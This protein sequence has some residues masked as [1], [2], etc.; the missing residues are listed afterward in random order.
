MSDETVRT[1]D[2]KAFEL[3]P[4]LAKALFTTLD[5]AYMAYF[6]ASLTGQSRKESEQQIAAIPEDKRYLTRLLESLDNAFADFDTELALLDLPYM[7]KHNP[8]A[9]KRYLEFR[10]VQYKMLLAVVTDYLANRPP[11]GGQS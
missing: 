6:K 8:E 5:A 10:A 1:K 3:T 9:I 4:G 11:T 7:R 2:L